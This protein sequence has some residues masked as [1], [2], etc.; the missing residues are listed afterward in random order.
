MNGEPAQGCQAATA[1]WE[2]TTAPATETSIPTETETNSGVSASSARCVAGLGYEITDDGTTD[3]PIANAD[4]DGLPVIDGSTGIVIKGETGA[5]VFYVY[6]TDGQATAAYVGSTSNPDIELTAPR[7]DTIAIDN[8][9]VM[10]DGG[11]NSDDR[12]YLADCFD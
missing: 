7:V 9:L 1:T 12:F 4:G 5:G 10:S 11:F 8:V 3:L 6:E 2:A